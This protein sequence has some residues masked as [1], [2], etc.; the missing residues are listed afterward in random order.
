[1]IVMAQQ[2]Y[3]MKVVMIG[4]LVIGLIG[5]TVDRL[6]LVLNRS[7]VGA[8]HGTSGDARRAS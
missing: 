3:N 1:M 8:L 7:V 2:M 5:F 4:I 6:L